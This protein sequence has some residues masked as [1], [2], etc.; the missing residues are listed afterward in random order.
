MLIGKKVKIRRIE[1]VDIPVLCELHE[2]SELYL[3]E[4]I[5]PDL[6]TDEIGEKFTEYFQFTGDF[7]IEGK[8]DEVFGI[9]SYSDINW[10]NRTCT[11]SFQLFKNDPDKSVSF[12][13]LGVML[14]FIISELNLNKVVIYTPEYRTKEI[15]V[16]KMTGFKSEGR[17]R[18]HIYTNGKFYDLLVYSFSRTSLRCVGT[19][20]EKT[21]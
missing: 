8:I 13:V 4:R 20:K 17:L 2:E 1:K 16:L 19:N 9:C 14:N 11:F 3:F 15:S 7:I 6:S 5:C 12:D 10:K 18:K 21:T